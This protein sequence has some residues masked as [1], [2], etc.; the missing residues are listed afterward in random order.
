MD[1]SRVVARQREF[2]REKENSV[3]Q[4]KLE[5]IFFVLMLSQGL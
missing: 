4:Q 1:G 2:V 3:T 5:F